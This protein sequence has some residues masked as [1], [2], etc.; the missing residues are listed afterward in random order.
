MAS[1]R[2][3]PYP[4]DLGVDP[5]FPL[6]GLSKEVASGWIDELKE[7]AAR[8]SLPVGQPLTLE[9][10]RAVGGREKALELPPRTGSL[11]LS[12]ASPTATSFPP[13]AEFW[14]KPEFQSTASQGGGR[15]TSLS[16][17]LLRQPF[18]VRSLAP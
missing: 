16:T 7:L 18:D 9:V 11:E 13:A 1:D 12:T 10:V 6:D 14:W 5:N 4:R 8:A 3:G 15:T 17:D 2:Q